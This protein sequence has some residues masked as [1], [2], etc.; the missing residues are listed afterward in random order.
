[1][2]LT[3]RVAPV[4]TEALPVKA[5]ERRAAQLPWHRVPDRHCTLCGRLL[6]RTHVVG[7][8]KIFCDADCAELYRT[9]WLP[10]RRSAV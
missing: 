3:Y 6:I 2:G 5:S 8:G 7:D 1:M 4:G 10:R 9:Y